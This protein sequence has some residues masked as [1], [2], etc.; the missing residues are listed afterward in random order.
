MGG[1]DVQSVVGDIRDKLAEKVQ[2]PPGYYYTFGGQFQNLEEA[3]DRLL[4]A[5]PFSLLLIFLLLYV[6]FHSFG[7]AAL[8][9]TSIPMSA[10]GGVFALMLRGMPF[11]ISAGVGF[12]ALFG[13]AVLNGIV[14]MGTY[15]QLLKEG[16]EDVRERVLRGSALR[17]RP[18]LMTA[19]V[20]SLGFLP[21]ALSTSAGAEVQKPLATV[22]I[23]G[24]ISATLLTLFVLPLL[25]WLFPSR[26]R[27]KGRTVG[28]A[29][30]LLLL[31]PVF[32]PRAE[33]Q[34][35]QL[36]Q[37]EDSLVARNPLLS[38][39]QHGVNA[40]QA[41]RAGAFRLPRFEA[42]LEVGLSSSSPRA[43]TLTVSQTFPF[44]SLF[45]LRAQGAKLSVRNAELLYQQRE[46]D[47]RSQLRLHYYAAQYLHHNQEVLQGLDTL[48][49]H[50]LEVDRLRYTTGEA[51]AVD[52]STAK[53][54]YFSE[55]G[56]PIAGQESGFYDALHR[57]HGLVV[58]IGIP[59]DFWATRSAAR[60][61]RFRALAAE[62]RAEDALRQL[63]AQLEASMRAYRVAL[64]RYRY[65]Q[66]EA[67]PNA[68]KIIS[69]ARLAFDTGEST[70][71]EYLY[72]LQTAAGIRL[73]YLK[74]VDQVNQIA[75]RILALLNR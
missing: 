63:Q 47:L 72:A 37:L 6:T 44:P 24:L 57:S 4:I 17:L 27:A 25:Y 66:E 40:A 21:M 12:I 75:V 23:G 74:S 53:V 7:Q 59:L 73:E 61:G 60:A 51:R 20:A 14:L 5:V 2:L 39:M 58:G 35:L 34:G 64:Q 48:Y 3:S 31:I 46:I 70:S 16:V 62:A 69:S 29:A 8:I 11:S 68:R 45:Y 36:P 33:A 54:G 41:E 43:N 49:H 30:A 15:N 67:L 52:V 9:F 38:S 18:V 56:D 50:Y 42:E 26:V 28:K 65:F 32:A 71:V 22:V 10:I 55:A 19:T 13:V 1:R